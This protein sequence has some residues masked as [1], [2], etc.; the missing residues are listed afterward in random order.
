VE[1]PFASDIFITPPYLLAAGADEA[2]AEAVGLA[3]AG[4]DADEAGAGDDEADAETLGVVEAG[5]KD[6]AGLPQA[7]TNK[8][9]SIII[10]TNI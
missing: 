7:T 4:E 6:V 8:L 5:A 10:P 9:A 2:G 1:G 3:V